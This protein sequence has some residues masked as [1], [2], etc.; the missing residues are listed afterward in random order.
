MHLLR[1]FFHNRLFDILKSGLAAEYLVINSYVRG[2]DCISLMTESQETGIDGF[3]FHFIRIFFFDF[4]GQST[5]IGSPF[6]RR[7]VGVNCYFNH[8]NSPPYQFLEA[9]K[10]ITCHN[11]FV[12][13]F[14]TAFSADVILFHPPEPETFSASK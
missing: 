3:H 2:L 9:D 12:Q 13:I 4:P 11:H 6:S 7:T 14:L 1:P 10:L 8:D 5:E